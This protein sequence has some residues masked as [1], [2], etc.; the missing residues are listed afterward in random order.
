MRLFARPGAWLG[1][2]LAGATL[3]AAAA[4]TLVVEGEALARRASVNGGA[5]SVQAMEPFGRGWS[6]DAQLFWAGG[7]IGA[8]LDLPI[9]VPAT[10]VYAVEVSLTRAPDYSQVQ[11]EVE[12]Q[13]ST[14]T[15]DSYAPRVAPPEL[16]S[17]G[18]F[19]LQ[20]GSRRIAFKIV[21]KNPRST[22]YALGLDRI[23]LRPLAA[24]PAAA[25]PAQ[26]V[27]QPRVAAAAAGPLGAAVRRPAGGGSS[28]GSAPGPDCQSTC[29]GDV[30]SVY[31]KSDGGTCQLW[32]RVPCHPYD[33]DA[34]AGVCRQTCGSDTD[35]SQG[36]KCDS[37]TGRCASMPVSCIDSQTLRLANGQTVSC[38]PYKCLGV[39]CQSTCGGPW[40]CASGASCN[41]A[42][43][44]CVNSPKKP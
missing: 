17:A 7:A 8:V 14:V 23:T 6:G 29:L 33:C 30:S 15:I 32:F 37:N 2:G 41:V 25:E 19:P 40:D 21:G 35:C 27:D 16:T 28:R 18:G 38:S 1:L 5:A 34:G 20:A 10:A 9:D 24:V 11:V 43:G 42:T 13:A 31:R 4:Q 44:H 39:V 36:G 22:G 3:A 26:P 12:G